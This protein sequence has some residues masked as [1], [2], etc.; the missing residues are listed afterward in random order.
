M[1][2]I[3]LWKLLPG[4]LIF[5]IGILFGFFLVYFQLGGL[6]NPFSSANTSIKAPSDW[7]PEENI[8]VYKDKIVIDIPES[9]M[10]RY[11]DTGSMKP[12]FDKGAN[13]IRI[14]PSSEAQIHV[15]DIITFERDGIFIVH[16]VIEI[17]EDNE[18]KYFITRG[19]NNSENDGKVRFTDVKYVTVAV[20]Y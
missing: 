1:A 17:G 20:V 9:S 11:A 16:R 7:I 19:D 6:E 12:V 4:I 14:V 15:G 18:G 10:S 5:L 13:G 2:K 8:H 3:Y